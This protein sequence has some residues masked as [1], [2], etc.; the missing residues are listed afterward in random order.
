MLESVFETQDS[1]VLPLAT[2]TLEQQGI[3]YAVRGGG[4]LDALRLPP[5]RLDLANRRA[6]PMAIVLLDE[7]MP[8][9]DGFACAEQIRRQYNHPVTIVM[10]LLSAVMCGFT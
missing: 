4:T 10:M 1:A 6:E 8:D 7:Q 5:D 2:V 9:M 3:E